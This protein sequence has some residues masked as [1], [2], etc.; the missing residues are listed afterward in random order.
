MNR[1]FTALNKDSLN[2]STLFNPFSGMYYGKWKD[3]KQ[4]KRP[5]G[6]SFHYSKFDVISS[7]F[8][9]SIWRIFFQNLKY[10]F[11]DRPK[12]KK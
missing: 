8:R 3:G 7:A 6:A 12:W 11:I 4:S 2:P 10:E 5:N 9:L 1:F